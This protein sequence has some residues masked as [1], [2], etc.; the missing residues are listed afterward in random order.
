MRVAFHGSHANSG[1]RYAAY[2]CAN[3]CR[4]I[5]AAGLSSKSAPGTTIDVVVP[6][7]GAS[8]A[9]A[10]SSISAPIGFDTSPTIA[11]NGGGRRPGPAPKRRRRERNPMRLLTPEDFQPWIGKPVRVAAVPRPIELVLERI[12]HRARLAGTDLRQPF[13]LFFESEPGAYLL[14]ATY[15]F[16][17]GRGGP[18]PIYITQLM[19]TAPRRLYQ[20][21][22]S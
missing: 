22:F 3:S 12:E 14:D 7:K 9:K 17:C 13:S 10:V 5:S 16:D 15:Q 6:G 1:I 8:A 2:S 20:P 19:P 4:L 18:H 11:L 21:V